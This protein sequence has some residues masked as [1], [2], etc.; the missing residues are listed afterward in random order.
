MTHFS[1]TRCKLTCGLG[2]IGKMMTPATTCNSRFAGGFP[3]LTGIF[4]R[5]T[6]KNS[7]GTLTSRSHNSPVRTPIRVTLYRWK[8]D[9][10]SFPKICCMMHFEH[11]KTPKTALENWV[12][13]GYARENRGG[14]GG[15]VAW[16]IRLPCGSY[17]NSRGTIPRSA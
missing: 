10:E 16:R 14:F 7:S 3:R 1:P 2:C 13:K 4:A 12:R 6:R 11:W 17:T 15:G 5:K 8:V 9:I